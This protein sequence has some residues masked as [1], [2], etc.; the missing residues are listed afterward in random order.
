MLYV[1]IVLGDPQQV[2]RP[3]VG[4]VFVDVMDVIGPLRLITPT[5][6]DDPVREPLPAHGDIAMV[7]SRPWLVGLAEAQEL[8]ITRHSI[9]VVE[10]AILDAFVKCAV[11][12][13]LSVNAGMKY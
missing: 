10:V 9:D 1:V 7:M 5:G 4:L 8:P 3:I 11:Q 2:L 12:C 6:R 13:G